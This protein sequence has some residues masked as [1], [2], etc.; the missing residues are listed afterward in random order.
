MARIQGPVVSSVR[1]RARWAVRVASATSPEF[2]SVWHS[3]ISAVRA[4]TGS[5]SLAR[6]SSVVS[7]CSAVSN[8]ASS[9]RLIAL[10]RLPGSPGPSS[11]SCSIG[12]A[13]AWPLM[14]AVPTVR[15][16]ST[17]RSSSAWSG[18]GSMSASRSSTASAS[19]K[20]LA[21]SPSM[22]QKLEGRHDRHHR[23]RVT[24][25]DRVPEHPAEVAR[26][27]ARVV[28]GAHL[29][30]ADQPLPQRARRVDRPG[31]QG[32]LH[33]HPLAGL[34]E[35][36]RAVLADR[37]EEPVAHLV[38]LTDHHQ[39]LLRQVGDVGHRVAAQDG[40]GTGEREP[41]GEHR[42]R[43]ERLARALPQQ[44]PAPVDDRLEGLVAVRRRAV[45]AAQ[46]REP[47]LE[48]PAH[49]GHR[50][51][52]HLRGGQLD[53]QGQP[54]EAG[55]QPTDLRVIE[56]YAG[57][58]GHGPPVEE[59]DGVALAELRQLVDLLGGDAERGPRGRQ[60][61]QVGH[62]RGQERHGV[63]NGLDQVLA[64]VDDQQRRRADE[65]LGNAAAQVRRRPGVP[66]GGHRVAHAQGR[67]DLGQHPLGRVDAGQLHQL[68]D[69]LLGE[70]ADEVR[71]P[72]LAQPTRAEDRDDPGVVEQRPD[73]GDVGVAADHRRRVVLQP[74]PHRGVAGQQLDVE[75]L[76]LLTWLGAQTVAGLLGVRRI[77]RERGRH[78]AGRGLGPQQP[79]EELLV[80]RMALGQRL[81]QVERLGVVAEGEVGIGQ[82]RARGVVIGERGRDQL[83]QRGIVGLPRAGVD[84]HG[85]GRLRAHPR[86]VGVAGRLCRPGLG[87]QPPQLEDVDLT[88]SQPEPVSAP[89]SSMT[90]GS[91]RDRVRETR[92]WRAF[93]GC[94]GSS[95]SHTLRTS[96][97]AETGLGAAAVSTASSVWARAPGTGSPRQRTPSS[98]VSAGPPM[99]SAE[100]RRRAGRRQTPR[101]RLRVQPSGRTARE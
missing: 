7:S 5:G 52:P 24:Q 51:H 53:R 15:S 42:Q 46:Q 13:G 81:E 29:F 45:A 50:H 43:A 87:N 18:V 58:R 74:L 83:G 28:G 26:L 98:R 78:P 10:P 22:V 25:L 63:G 97:P 77:A 33:A 90:C 2:S 61:P 73:R 68:D 35:P 60:H 17:P 84:P 91:V 27:L 100:L 14:I 20:T 56:A 49:V 1:V 92:T 4:T 76:Q 40:V 71:H 9:T 23:R 11:R 86:G 66:R 8:M 21:W 89:L 19:P 55:H 62:A 6:S 88:V 70:P 12:R 57:T 101:W 34:V 72:R 54:V 79:G 41:V 44:L 59:L 75:P 47:V 99:V 96:S 3:H 30:L 38:V 67:G 85:E 31:E 69:G 95:S 64:V 93:S 94:S 82:H 32:L 65:V 37:L 36:L 48:P 16:A 80:A 39:R